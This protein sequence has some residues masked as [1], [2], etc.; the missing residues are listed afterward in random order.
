MSDYNRE[1]DVRITRDVEEFRPLGESVL[2]IGRFDGV[3]LG[4]VGLVRAV[5]RAAAVDHIERSIVVVL[6]PPPEWVLRPAESRALLTTLE[7]RLNLL[8]ELGVSEV[9]VLPFDKELSEQDPEEFIRF[10]KKRFLMRKFVTGPNA[11]IG[12]NRSGTTSALTRIAERVGF[13][14]VTVPP[15]GIAGDI[16]SSR[17]RQALENGDIVS[18]TDILGRP[19]SLEGPVVHGDARGRCLGFPTANLELPEWMVLPLDGVYA[20]SAVVQGDRLVYRALVS[21]GIRPTFG[22]GDRIFEVN[23]LDF[24][25]DI[26][27][28]RLRVFLQKRIRRQESFEETEDLVAAMRGDEEFVRSMQPVRESDLLP[29]AS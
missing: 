7:D 10:L 18:V 5:I 15:R 1:G 17:A 2:T 27:G 19:H 26:Y 11:A 9:V 21:V 24:D 8:S 25:K 22:S 4:H 13:D 29:F 28:R 14:H 6:W 20:A 23:L 12:R 3:H 16:S